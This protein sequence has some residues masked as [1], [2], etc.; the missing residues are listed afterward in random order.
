MVLGLAR[1]GVD[2]RANI[3]P[4]TVVKRLLL[5]PEETGIGVLVKMRG[6]QVVGEGRDLFNTTDGYVLDASFFTSLSKSEVDLTWNTELACRINSVDG[7]ETHQ[8]RECDA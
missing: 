2:T 8:C 3:A 4:G 1:S 6:D 7:K 5:T